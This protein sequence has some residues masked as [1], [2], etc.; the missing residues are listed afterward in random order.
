[1]N[2]NDM[3]LR[4]KI[5]IGITCIAVIALIIA[6]V[7]LAFQKTSMEKDVYENAVKNLQTSANNKIFAKKSVG[8]SNAVSISNDGNIKEALKT[9]NRELAINSLKELGVNMKASTEFKNIKIHLHTKDNR[10]FVRAWKPDKF[11]DDLSSFRHSIVKANSQKTAV[12]TFELGKAGLSIRSVLPIIDNGKHLGSIEFIQG[13]NSV[14]RSMD[15]E[16]DAF[17][18]L[19]DKR[20]SSVKQFKAEKIFKTN[21]II[22]QKF[23]N[24][25]FMNDAKN[26]DMNVFL[27][28]KLFI[29]NNYLYTYIDIKDF[30]DQK[31]GIAILASPMEKVNLAIQDANTLINTALILII[32]LIIFVLF[33]VAVATQK[34]VIYPLIKL[35][36]AIQNLIK[37]SDVSNK[38]QKDSNDE[39]GQVADS[40]NEYLSS[41]ENGIKQDSLVIEDVSNIVTQVT[42]GTLSGRITQTANNPSINELTKVLNGMMESLQH[43]IG[44]SLDTLKKYQNEDFRSKTT[45]QCSGEICDLMNGINDL[46]DR[47][48]KMLIENKSNGLTLQQSSNTLLSNVAQLSRSSNEAAASLEETAAALEEMTG[49]I[50]NSTQNVVKMAEYANELNS[51]SQQGR[52]LANETTVAMDE[53]NTEVTAINEAIT[54]ID[55]IAF[56]TNILS[57]NAAVEAAT[58]GEAGKG[59]AVVAQEVRNLASRSAEAANEIKTLVENATKKA[60]SGKSISDRMIQGYEGLNENINKTIELISDVE[61]SSKEQQV[62]IEQINNSISMLDRQTQQN[63]NVATNAQEIANQ[64]EQLAQTIVDSANSK[65]FDGKESVQAKI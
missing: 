57:L 18:L 51:S 59:F 32:V 55:Q 63:A 3:K 44:H 56:Q 47:I 1:M 52:S 38:I 10:S 16:K 24:K 15:R 29:T 58:A 41:I 8:I 33:G 31:I 54:V 22:S 39:L 7:V 11:G 53:I 36:D 50:S 14:A 23:T 37:S 35:N 46:G 60:N 4:N 45:I 34:L 43:I 42:S 30:R 40:F 12:N 13:L 27:K 5:G 9:K 2:L 61:S 48:S 62:G 19:M 17:L 49:N 6:Y 65:E 64:T 20:L 25:D 26:I 21:Y 28:D